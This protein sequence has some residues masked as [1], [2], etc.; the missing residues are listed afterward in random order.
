MRDATDR[1]RQDFY[2]M[3]QIT[4]N[5]NTDRNLRTKMKTNVADVLYGSISDFQADMLRSEFHQ[6]V[7]WVANGG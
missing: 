3:L 5:H 7:K 4:I 1:K 2:G 6:M